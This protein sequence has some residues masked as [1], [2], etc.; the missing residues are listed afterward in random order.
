MARASA[1]TPP[2]PPLVLASSSRYRA[3]L[4]QRLHLDFIGEAPNI[5]EAPWAGEDVAA[6]VQRLA[7]AKAG[8]L[9]DR[10]PDAW[11]IGSDQ[12]AALDGQILGKPGGIEQARAQLRACSGREVRFLTAVALIHGGRARTALD[13]T[14]VRFRPLSAGEIDRYIELEPAL[15]CAGSF[16]CEGYGISLFDAIETTDPT[17]LIGL[18][19]I[20]VRRLL[21]EM[22]LPLP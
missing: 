22:G 7:L 14:T 5:D 18:P 16:K 20:S 11:I 6:L 4:L 17:A 19:L 13:V 9:R 1:N 8:A 15:D 2:R 3:E 12:A 10:Y 21:D